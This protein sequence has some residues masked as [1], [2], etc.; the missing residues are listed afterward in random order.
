MIVR[1]T[2]KTARH[3]LGALQSAGKPDGREIVPFTDA[4]AES[5]CKA[6]NERAEKLGIQT[7]YVVTDK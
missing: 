1:T 6:A 2:E 3:P 7:R 5:H 4:E